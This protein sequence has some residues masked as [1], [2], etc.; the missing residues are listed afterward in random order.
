MNHLLIHT[1]L[2][3]TCIYYFLIPKNVLYVFYLFFYFFA[4]I[5]FFFL[6]TALRM[7]KSS[8]SSVRTFSFYFSLFFFLYCIFFFYF[9]DSLLRLVSFSIKVQKLLVSPCVWSFIFMLKFIPLGT[10]VYIC[11]FVNL[12]VIFVVYFKN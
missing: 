5:Q 12:I 1:H 4:C 7:L 9:V 11:H 6:F 2:C 10:L 3:F 8:S